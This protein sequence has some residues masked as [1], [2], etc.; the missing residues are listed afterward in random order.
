MAHQ[1]LNLKPPLHRDSATYIDNFAPFIWCLLIKNIEEVEDRVIDAEDFKSIISEM[2]RHWEPRIPSPESGI[3]DFTP[4]KEL[5]HRVMPEIETAN[6]F[7]W[8]RHTVVIRSVF[9][10]K[11]GFVGLGSRLQAN[12]DEICI[13][14]GIDAPISILGPSGGRYQLGSWPLLCSWAYEW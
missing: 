10:T 13:V 12:G 3:I 9:L 11:E 5:L 1:Q 8:M 4:Y 7:D 2:Q 14:P 6:F